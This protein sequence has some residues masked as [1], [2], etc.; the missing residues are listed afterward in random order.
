MEG[1]G[2]VMATVQIGPQGT[3]NMQRI[4]MWV[5]WIEPASIMYVEAMCAMGSG[6]PSPSGTMGLEQLPVQSA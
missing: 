6:G 3:T 1:A 2:V 4:W 5:T